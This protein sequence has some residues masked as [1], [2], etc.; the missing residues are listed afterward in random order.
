MTNP[1]QNLIPNEPELKD[2]LKLTRKEIFLN[3]NCHHLAKIQTFNPLTQTATASINYKQTYSLPNPVTGVYVDKLVNY[4]LLIDCPV[5]FLGG[6]PGALTFPVAK[7]DDCIVMFNDRDM[8]NWYQGSST[9]APATPRLHSFADA[10]I[11]VGL[12]NQTSVLLDFDDSRPAL[13]NGLLARVAVDTN[14]VAMEYDTTGSKVR[15]GPKIAIENTIAG[16][17]GVLLQQLLTELQSLTTAVAAITVTGVTPGGGVSGPPANAP[18]ILA[19]GVQIATTATQ[20][21]SLLE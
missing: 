12:R 9:S 15:V 18:A 2:L 21:G 13:R 1:K 16:T 14:E 5:M 20:I 11:L 19:I 8:D 3:L 6:G 4:P 7:G 10:I 17:L